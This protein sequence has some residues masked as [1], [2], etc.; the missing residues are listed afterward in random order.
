M[1]KLNLLL[2]GP[3]PPPLG[4]T[5]VLF[6]EL[7]QNVSQDSSVNLHVVDSNV[8]QCKSRVKR[9]LL[10]ARQALRIVLCI[11]KV[12][13][14]GVHVTNTKLLVTTRFVGALCRLANKPLIVRKFGGPD[15]RRRLPDWDLIDPLYVDRVREALNK[16]SLYLS[17]SRHSVDIA[18]QDGIR[19][20]DWFPNNKSMKGSFTARNH[21]CQKFIYLGHVKPT[22][23]L[24]EILAVAQSLPQPCSIDVYGPC[25]DG[26][27]PQ[28]FDNVRRVTY[29][30][31]LSPDKVV[32]KMNE[33]DALLLPTFHG[34]EG[35]PG[36]ILEA[37]AAGIPVIAS[38]WQVIPELVD[39]TSGVLIEPQDPQSLLKGMLRLIDDKNLYAKLCRGVVKKRCEFDSE[40]WAA[41]YLK[42]CFAL[43]AK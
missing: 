11:A 3:L 29:K 25:L 12:D 17:E 23:G 27:S 38:R 30:G 1:K 43:A 19:H 7:V 24:G 40:L 32:T 9:A 41:K 39:E 28:D 26:M 35:Y 5:T 37:Y 15:H 18:R 33:Y 31:Q 34:G 4:G 2:I 10:L 16:A 20:A 22:K 6:Q 14:V 36:V 13:V 21:S 8:G 42:F